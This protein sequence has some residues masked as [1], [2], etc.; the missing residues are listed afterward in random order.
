MQKQVKDERRVE[1]QA[2]WEKFCNS[3][4]L[5]AN[6]NKSW[7]KIKNFLKPKG[8]RDYPTLRHDGKVAKTNTDKKVQ[9]FAKSVERHF[10]IESEHFDS[11]HFNQ[12]NKFMEDNHRYF[13][14]LKTQMTTDL[15]WAMSPS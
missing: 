5:E 11:K 4:S 9:L 15:T 14:L 3:I 7:R 2:S 8:Q 6:P 1:T 10:G 13:I 12:V